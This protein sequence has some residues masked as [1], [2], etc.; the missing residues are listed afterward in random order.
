MLAFL[1]NLGIGTI[2]S[3][4][5]AAYEA[6]EKAKTDTERI[7]ADTAIRT[8]EA[9]RDV[10]V[11]EAGSRL[12]ALIRALFALPPAIYFAKLYLW[13]KVLQLGTTDPLSDEL[14]WV[15]TA[16]IGFYFLHDTARAVMRRK[17]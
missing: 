7:K 6:R 16:V 1:A 12:N 15:A 3:R 17:G 14:W 8:L 10:M 4:L 5:A 13:D 2:V 11:A 9:R